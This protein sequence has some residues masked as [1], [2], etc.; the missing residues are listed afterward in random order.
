[1]ELGAYV[2]QVRVSAVLETAFTS[3]VNTMGVDADP[4]KWVLAGSGE[5]SERL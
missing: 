5:R 4:S 2:V 3:A 1:M